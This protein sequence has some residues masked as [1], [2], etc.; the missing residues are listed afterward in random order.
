VFLCA[1]ASEVK[2]L[3]YTVLIELVFVN[4][5]HKILQNMNI[6]KATQILYNKLLVHEDAEENN[7]CF[8]KEVGI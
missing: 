8:N 4:L 7:T 2:D 1:F 3:V 5:T 6:Q